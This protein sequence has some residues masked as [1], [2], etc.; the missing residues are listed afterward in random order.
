MRQR[1]QSGSARYGLLRC[2]PRSRIGVGAVPLAAQRP[3]GQEA[4]LAAS[5]SL[6]A[7]EER[8]RLPPATPPPVLE[9]KESAPV[10]VFTNAP[11]RVEHKPVGRKKSKFDMQLEL[12]QV[13]VEIGNASGR[14]QGEAVLGQRKRTRCCAR[15]WPASARMQCPVAAGFRGRFCAARYPGGQQSSAASALLSIWT[16]T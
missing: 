3:P 14:V 16:S 8:E 2:G 6:H 1:A 9:P 4:K 12:R 5:V 11:P 13:A 7:D 10:A 15:W